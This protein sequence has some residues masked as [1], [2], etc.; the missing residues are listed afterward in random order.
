[1]GDDAS[2]YD[3]APDW[4]LF[5]QPIY[6]KLGETPVMRCETLLAFA[7]GAN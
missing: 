7:G 3:A 2:G 1:M 6:A 5:Q 4:P